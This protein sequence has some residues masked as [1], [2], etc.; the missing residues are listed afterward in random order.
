M[1]SYR[2]GDKVLF[3]FQSIDDFIGSIVT[4]LSVF[5]VKFSHDIIQAKNGCL[6]IVREIQHAPTNCQRWRDSSIF[7]QFFVV[8]WND[9]IL[10]RY[11]LFVV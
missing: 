3:L 10:F 2:R 9:L 5:S 4:R 7:S 8:L 1:D 11:I 6:C